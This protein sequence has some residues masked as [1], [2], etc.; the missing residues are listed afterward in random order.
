M[1]IKNQT[2][3][4]NSAKFSRFQSAVL[5]TAMDQKE[6]ILMEARDEKQACFGPEGNGIITS[7]V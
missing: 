4:D 2:A 3:S 6:A 7:G 5:K 1:E